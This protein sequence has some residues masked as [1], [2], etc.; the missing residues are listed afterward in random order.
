MIGFPSFLRPNN[1]LLYGQTTFCSSVG[2]LGHFYLLAILNDA[3]ANTVCRYLFEPLLS[4]HFR[5]CVRAGLPGHRV[6]LCPAF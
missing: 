1:I 3:A 5:V 4:L 2:H 6:A